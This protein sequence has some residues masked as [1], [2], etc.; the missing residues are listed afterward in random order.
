MAL[1]RGR[2]GQRDQ[3]GLLYPINF[4][5]ACARG[6]LVLNRVLSPTRKLR[7]HPGHCSPAHIE[8]RTN[9]GIGPSWPLHPLVCLEKNPRPRNRPCV[10]PSL[11]DDLINL[12]SLLRR[13]H[14]RMVLGTHA[15][16]LHSTPSPSPV[17]L[18]LTLLHKNYCDRLLGQML[19]VENFNAWL[20]TTRALDQEGAVLRVAVPAA[21]N[22]T[23][24][25]QKLGGKVAGALDKIDYDAVNVER[26]GR[27]AYVVET[28][29]C[30]PTEATARAS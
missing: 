7:T 19:T 10:G 5:W 14:N 26:V 18:F 9:G 11:L 3:V 30:A 16:S 1:R 25:E 6:A 12:N 15:T 20:A 21:F 29:V 4:R 27:V 2:T 8:R 23:W 28:T 24:L 13:E 22:K 17:S